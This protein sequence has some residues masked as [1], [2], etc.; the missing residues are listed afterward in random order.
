MMMLGPPFLSMFFFSGL[1]YWGSSCF[2][3]ICH[4][5]KQQLCTS[6]PVAGSPAAA[7]FCHVFIARTFTALS[8]SSWRGFDFS[9]NSGCRSMGDASDQQAALHDTYTFSMM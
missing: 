6:G 3:A 2:L 9:W 5:H 1:L 8:F 7:L 4:P